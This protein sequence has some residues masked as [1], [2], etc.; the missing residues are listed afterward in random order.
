MVG[1]AWVIRSSNVAPMRTRFLV[2]LKVYIRQNW[3]T[4]VLMARNIQNV[5]E[6]YVFVFTCVAAC[7]PKQYL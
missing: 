2:Y 6:S 5:N 1:L 4:W 3:L 7:N